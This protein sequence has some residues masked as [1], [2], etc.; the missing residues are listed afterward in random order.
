MP[1]DSQT[2]EPA[3]PRERKGRRRL[4]RRALDLAVVVAL[5]PAI[6][7]AVAAFGVWIGVM[8][9]REG[10]AAFA[11]WLSPRLALATIGTGLLALLAALFAD[12]D[13]LWL[14]A[15]LALSLTAATIG[16]YLWSRTA[17]APPMAREA[18]R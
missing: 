1:F 9:W 12:F 5:G 17:P 10:F 18:P 15:L 16:G 4:G 2:A 11:A 3:P 7:I 14:R 8:D 6:F 13:R